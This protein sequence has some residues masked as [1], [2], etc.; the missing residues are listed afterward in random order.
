[1]EGAPRS[2]ALKNAFAPWSILL[3]SS[4]LLNKEASSMDTLKCFLKQASCLI[5]ICYKKEH[6]IVAKQNLNDYGT[7]KYAPFSI[8]LQKGVPRKSTLNASGTMLPV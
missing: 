1:M 8:F 7:L 2:N 4:N 6:Q 3:D 5:Q